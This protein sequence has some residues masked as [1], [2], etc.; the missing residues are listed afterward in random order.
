MRS[1]LDTCDWRQLEKVQ[2]EMFSRQW[3]MYVGN[4]G[5]GWA[6]VTGFR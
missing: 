6:A 2:L 4:S 5:D 1:V 3:E